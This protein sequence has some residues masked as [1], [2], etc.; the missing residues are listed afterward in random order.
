M[1]ALLRRFT[2]WAVEQGYGCIVNLEIG[3]QTVAAATGIHIPG[4]D[5]AYYHTVGR[6][7]LA[8]PNQ[9]SPG[10]FMAGQIIRWAIDRGATR[11]SLGQGFM[12]YKQVLGG[13]VYPQWELTI[14]RSKP[15]AVVMRTVDPA[16]HYTRAQVVRLLSRR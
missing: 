1:A 9:Y 10:L 3:G 2:L 14:A 5:A 6:H 15:A 16:I 7:P 8:L 12:P 11:L 4:Q 13:E